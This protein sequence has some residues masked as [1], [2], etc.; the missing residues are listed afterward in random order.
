[1]VLL[2]MKQVA[3]RVSPSLVDAFSRAL[4]ESSRPRR[5]R[6]YTTNIFPEFLPRDTVPS[7]PRRGSFVDRTVAYTGLPD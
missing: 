4:K 7:D 3:R 1:M 6:R 2:G 5:S